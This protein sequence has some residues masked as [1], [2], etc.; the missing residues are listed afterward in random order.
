MRKTEWKTLFAGHWVACVKS[1]YTSI[2]LI[3]L[4]CF[5]FHKFQ[6]VTGGGFQSSALFSLATVRKHWQVQLATSWMGNAQCVATQ[7]SWC[8]SCCYC[9]GLLFSDQ[10]D[11]LILCTQQ[12]GLSI[13]PPIHHWPSVPKTSA[14]ATI[15]RHSSAARP[16]RAGNSPL[17]FNNDQFAAKSAVDKQ[18]KNGGN[19]N[20]LHWFDDVDDDDDKEWI[21]SN[22]EAQCSP[23]HFKLPRNTGSL[24]NAKWQINNNTGVSSSTH[25]LATS[26]ADTQ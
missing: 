25:Q 15:G 13:L 4:F 19:Y 21:S 16:V 7:W 3:R 6:L 22:G 11:F 14:D 24:R 12:A 20:S 9:K 10:Y 2:A 18:M 1:A 8:R 26:R 23:S 17:C 5:L